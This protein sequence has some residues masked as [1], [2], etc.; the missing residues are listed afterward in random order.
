M[1]SLLY[2]MQEPIRTRTVIPTEFPARHAAT[3]IVRP[4]SPY[5]IPLPAQRGRSDDE[6]ETVNYFIYK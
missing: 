2:R 3:A 5:Q 6:R 4:S 1:S